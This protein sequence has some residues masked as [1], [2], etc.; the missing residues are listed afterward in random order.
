MSTGAR[1]STEPA[2][3]EVE[4]NRGVHHAAVST[5][6][7]SAAERRLRRS[8]II[9]EAGK[10]GGVLSRRLLLEL[11][12]TRWEIR[13]ELNAGRWRALGRQTIRICEG[14]DR[15]A[16]W[17]RAIF[18][19]GVPAVLDGVSALVAGGLKGVD[20]DAVHVAVPKSANPRRC[21]GVIVHET[22]RY[23]PGSVLSTARVPR[24]KPAT[25]AT[26]AALWARSD[27]Q[28]ALYVLASG[29]Q[30]LFT[31]EELAEEVAK[32]R[33]DKRRRLLRGLAADLA[34]GIE[35][36]CERD[37]ALMCRGRGYPEP[38]R[39]TIRYT[40]S[41]RLVYDNDFDPYDVTAEIDGSQH[42]DPASW[43][44]DAFKQNVVSLEGRTVIR[45]PNL[46][47]RLDPDPFFDQL[48]Q[49]LRRGGWTGPTSRRRPMRRAS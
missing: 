39:Q 36:I 27:R 31:P 11:G 38:T 43:I 19:V 40:E 34:G 6:I 20:E 7:G 10:T 12:I 30:R 22:R 32:I 29:Q 33:R 13:A 18:E 46:A 41:G 2:A 48:G 49:A 5:H 23:E 21:S 44:G 16:A 4:L 1:L 24:M 47:L 3:G 14:D 15:L 45:I 37:F 35:S 17:W 9:A 25:A 26:H 28:A 42:L 8:R